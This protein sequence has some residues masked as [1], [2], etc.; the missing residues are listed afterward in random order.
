MY[1]LHSSF[2]AMMEEDVVDSKSAQFVQPLFSNEGL[3]SGELDLDIDFKLLSDYLFTEEGSLASAGYE[4]EKL[5][6][7]ETKARKKSSPI[8]RRKTNSS[9]KSGTDISSV[10]VNA[11]TSRGSRSKGKGSKAKKEEEVGDTDDD[12]DYDDFDDD[13]LDD[14]GIDESSDLYPKDKLQQRTQRRR[15]RNRVLARKT[16]LRKKFFFES[17][18]RQVA[19]L[20]K[21]NKVLKEI[22]QKNLDAETY[23]GILSDCAELPSCIVSSANANS[24]LEKADLRLVSAIQRS[25]KSFCISDPNLLD[26]PIVFASDGFLQLTG[27][28]LDQV[29]GNNCRML[30]GDRTD[31][32]QIKIL[33]KG[34]TEG[35]D[36]S[37]TV[38]NYKADGTEFLNNIF[39]AALRDEN[40]NVV[41]YVGVQKEV[42]QDE[43]VGNVVPAVVTKRG[44]SRKTSAY[45]S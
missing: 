20:S 17:L 30:Q 13:D 24:I 41:N 14:E 6:E 18:Q 34:I 21:E 42:P 32:E 22:A 5:L 29:L 3:M 11:S 31:R 44:R 8:K 2:T 15:E 39:V 37:I 7:S 35:V 10:E 9:S 1:S 28:T 19:Q 38:Y 36:T 25:Q 27:Y 4:I 12:E 43:A 26:N 23:N 40:Q 16:R 45:P 33:T